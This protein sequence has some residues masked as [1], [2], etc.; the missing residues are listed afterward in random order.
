[1]TI[2]NLVENLENG[3]SKL[4]Y[5][6][7]HI[8]AGQ[9]ERSPDY[10]KLRARVTHIWANRKGQPNRSAMERSRPGEPLSRSWETLRNVSMLYVKTNF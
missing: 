1:M 10:Q 4:P 7:T 8:Y 9:R 5:F 2:T 3:Y 6:T